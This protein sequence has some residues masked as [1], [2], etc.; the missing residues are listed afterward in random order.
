MTT[1]NKFRILAATLIAMLSATAWCQ[2]DYVNDETVP[3][4]AETLAEVIDSKQHNKWTGSK[5]F[6]LGVQSMTHE[7][8]DVA[9]D[10]AEVDEAE[11]Y[12][13]AIAL[14]KKELKQHPRNA[15]A[16]CNIAICETH[17]ASISLNKTLV[18]IFNGEDVIK[19]PLGTS[20]EEKMAL[21]EAFYQEKLKEKESAV[22]N[23]LKLLDEGIAMLPAADKQSRCKALLA[24]SEIL[25]D[26]DFDDAVQEACLI[27]ATKVHPCDESYL[28]LLYFYSERNNT[29]KVEKCAQEAESYLPE[30]PIV[31]SYKAACAVKA[32]DYDKALAIINLLIAGDP[33]NAELLKMRASTLTHA[34]R[35]REAVDDLVAMANADALDDAYT[36]L[37]AIAVTSDENLNMVLDAISSQE[38][39]QVTDELPMNW[40]FVEAMMQ[41]NIAHD[42]PKALECA[43]KAVNISNNVSTL[44][45]LADV[46][47]KL[48][49]VDKALYILD[50]TA[51]RDEEND[52]VLKSKIDKEM[53]CGMADR[54]ITD[55]K[56]QSYLGNSDLMP[57]SYSCLGWAL[58]AKGDWKNAIAC[59][60]EWAKSDEGNMIP[61]YYKARAL[62]LAGQ[63]NEGREILTGILASNDFTGNEEMKMNIL[64]YLGR[65][66]ESRAI[67]DRLAASTEQVRAMSSNEIEEAEQL[68][69]VMSLYN[70]AC[71]FSLH[72]DS[73]K[74]LQYLKQHFESQQDDAINYDYSILDYDFDNVRQTPE[75]LNIINEFKTRWLKGEYKPAK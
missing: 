12:K 54:V 9:T 3:D 62:V 52:D 60:D 66:T 72:G 31:Q 55:S 49:D 24:K 2:D 5:N 65:T 4:N 47:Y 18:D 39:R 20:D 71:A 13:S 57:F 53:N 51:A 25:K 28:N 41:N 8:D 61:A 33:D 32:G 35:Y 19:I 50:V 22:N 14:F 45:F 15:Y 63:V 17:I 69:E 26:N 16:K 56:V 67:L 27:E 68:P 58:S 1:M 73:D 59:Y 36:P 42:Y 11:P 46:Y 44:M 74:S 6:V 21:L 34:K 70:L 37:A 43:K 64:Y 40:P 29:E 75:F 38:Q 23:A 10:D 7:I 30:N 48:G